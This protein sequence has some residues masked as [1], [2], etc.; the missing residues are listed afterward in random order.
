[1]SLLLLIVWMFMDIISATLILGPSFLPMLSAFHVDPLYFGLIFTV[2]LAFGCCTPPMG[3]SL[4]ISG[5]IANRDLIR[6][7]KACL[8]F[9]PYRSAY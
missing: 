6:V 2:N 5:S 1:M 9:W 4:Y 7:S 8:P 3:D